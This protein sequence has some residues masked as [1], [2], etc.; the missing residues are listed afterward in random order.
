MPGCKGVF[1]HLQWETV[2]WPRPY[3]KKENGLS[4]PDPKEVSG[5][6]RLSGC[7]GG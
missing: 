7:E 6:L 3:L 4:E 2:I 1:P 5:P